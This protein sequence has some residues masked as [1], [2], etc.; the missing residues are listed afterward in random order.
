MV[1]VGKTDEF[2]HRYMEKFRTFAA[3]FGHF[4]S[5][6]RDIATRDIGLH[7]AEP[8]QSGGAKLTACLCW[9]QMKGIMADTLPKEKAEAVPTFKYRLKVDHLKFWFLQPMPTYL[10]LYIESLDRFLILNLQKYVE[11]KW[12]RDILLLNRKTAEVE[13]SAGSVLDSDALN[14]ILRE[15]TVEEWVKAIAAD[16]SRVRLCQRDYNIIWRIGTAAARKVEHRFEIYDW[17]SKTRGEV[18]IQERS[19]CNT[20]DWTTVRNHWQFML[21]ATGVEEMYPYL[22]FTADEEGEEYSCNDYDDDESLGNYWDDD[23]EYRPTFKLKSGQIA[24]GEDCS[25]EFHLYYI[26]PELNDLGQNLFKLIKTLIDIKF[27]DIKNE[28]GEFVSI[29]PWHG[30]QV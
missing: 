5:Y 30:R 23:R 16:E 1:I 20:G 2:E 28:G 14:I 25:G 13:V 26:I 10:A 21:Q 8:L 9:F 12:G 11:E 27:I 4:V 29:A 24:A 3:Q 22:D 15:S 6:E 7:L 17:Q 18:H 19:E